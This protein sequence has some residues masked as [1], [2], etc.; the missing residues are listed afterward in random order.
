MSL[1]LMVCQELEWSKSWIGLEDKVTAL[2]ISLFKLFS[3]RLVEEFLGKIMCLRE[4]LIL[5]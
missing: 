3:I 2:I 1:D 4:S 5:L